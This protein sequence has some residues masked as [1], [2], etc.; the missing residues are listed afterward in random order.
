MAKIGNGRTR[1]I[2]AGLRLLDEQGAQGIS[3][4]RVARRLNVT[5]GS[6][7]H[8]FANRSEFVLALL[9]EWEGDYTL[10]V[11]AAITD[12]HDARKRLE[13]YLEV[14]AHMSPE[15][16]V[17]IRSWAKREAIVAE[18][19]RR[20]DLARLAFSVESCAMILPTRSEAELFGWICHLSAIGGQHSLAVEHASTESFGHFLMPLFDLMN[21]LASGNSKSGGK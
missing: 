6:F 3:I 18:V 15:R 8:H 12:C 5:R 14:T 10:S 13:R 1:W 2:I 21:R 17:A 9:A 16:E 7:Y 20:V 11:L 19:V 4:E